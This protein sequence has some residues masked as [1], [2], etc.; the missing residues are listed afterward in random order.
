[1]SSV[2]QIRSSKKFEDKTE[3][4][5]LSLK[6]Y[7][8]IAVKIIAKYAPNYNKQK[9]LN[10]EDFISMIIYRLMFSDY[11]FDPSIGVSRETL[12][13]NM[14]KNMFKKS[15][16]SKKEKNEITFTDYTKNENKVD[17]FQQ[18][19]KSVRLASI[20]SKID[21]LIRFSNLSPRNAQILRDCFLGQKKRREIA[22]E[23]GI[24]ISCVQFVIKESIEHLSKIAN[25]NLG[26]LI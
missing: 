5:Y 25:P 18:E 21:T 12:R 17:I 15:P 13:Y 16:P 19:E 20:H 23:H 24:S 9:L 2:S 3:V 8:D 1:M 7:E 4:E 6:E 14:V 22:E 10:D 26:D 11:C